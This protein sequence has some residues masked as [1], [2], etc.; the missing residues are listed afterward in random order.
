MEEEDDDDIYA[1]DESIVPESAVPTKNGVD[2]SAQKDLDDA[3]E[4]EEEGEEV[5]EEGSDSVSG[6]ASIRLLLDSTNIFEDIDIITE[7]KGAP[8]TKSESVYFHLSD[9]QFPPS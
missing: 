2:G 1:P 6:E 4:D 9:P 8:D 7:R 5:D 3:I